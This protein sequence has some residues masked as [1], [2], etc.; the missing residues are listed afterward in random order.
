MVAGFFVKPAARGKMMGRLAL[1]L[2]RTRSAAK[3][4][5]VGFLK[6]CQRRAA[7]AGR[8]VGTLCLPVFAL[9]WTLKKEILIWIQY[10][11]S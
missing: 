7:R 3:Q 10:F 8:L 11:S 4:N 2:S 6:T 9:R 5:I 1:S